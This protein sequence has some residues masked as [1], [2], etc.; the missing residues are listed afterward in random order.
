M[1]N[2]S[3]RS[4][5]SKAPA[6]AITVAVP[7]SA[8]EVVETNQER[9]R[10]LARELMEGFDSEYDLGDDH[11]RRIGRAMLYFSRLAEL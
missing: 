4:L 1:A 8:L 3:R 2:I 7:A 5:L 10:R 11:Y 9:L 6:V